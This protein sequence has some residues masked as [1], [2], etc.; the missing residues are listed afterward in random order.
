MSEASIVACQ[1]FMMEIL[2][3]NK[4]LTL[5]LRPIFLLKKRLR[6]SSILGGI[7]GSFRTEEPTNIKFFD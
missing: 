7:T 6:N 5:G 1:I 2:C 4:P 3:E